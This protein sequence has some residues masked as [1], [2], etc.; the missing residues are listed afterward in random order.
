MA[1]LAGFGIPAAFLVGLQDL[2][3][4]LLEGVKALVARLARGGAHIF[5]RF[6]FLRRSS[7]SAQLFL[8]TP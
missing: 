2:V 7:G 3:R 8:S 1:A 4:T 5:R 6:V